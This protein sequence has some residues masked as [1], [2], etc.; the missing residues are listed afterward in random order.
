LTASLA[1]MYTYYRRQTEV[2][3]Q[4]TQL[5][6]VDFVANRLLMKLFKTNNM[7]SLL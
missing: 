2:L 3:Y 6:A 4:T 5:N 1:H 7:H